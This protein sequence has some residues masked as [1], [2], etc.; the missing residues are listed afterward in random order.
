MPP[1]T[2]FRYILRRTI[3]AVGGLFAVLSALVILVDLIENM[4]FSGKVAGGDFGVALSM[5]LLRA[6]SNVQTL[7]PF[8]FLF[9]SIWMF[10]QLNKRSEI[11]V[12]RSAGLSV[13]RLLGPSA[14]I[15]A[16]SGFFIITAVDPLSAHFLSQAD[17]LK[18]RMEG[19]DRNLVRIFGDGI[20]LRQRDESGQLIINAA[21]Y[22]DARAALEKV[23]IWRFDPENTFLERLDASEAF[24]SG[25]TLELHDARL[26]A[27]GVEN[28]QFTPIYAVRTSLTSGNLRER[29]APPET[30]S[31][32][33]LPRFI[34]LA[35][36]AGVP[37]VRYN[38][39]FHDLCSTPLKLLAMVLIAAAFSM[40]PSRA[41]GALK[42]A[43]GSIVA[44]F[45]L[46][47]VSEISTALGE[48]GL[49]PAALAA[50]IPAVVASLAALTVLLHLEDG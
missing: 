36:A 44:G 13:W 29:V 9:G 19:N 21:N 32:W 46:F 47:I 49:A 39:R 27:P 38:I 48:S 41:G 5:T 24:L 22:D 14:L 30:L 45:A 28:E 25:R 26:R 18:S 6:P 35:E 34:L 17:N 23:T 1:I 33:R 50:W 16:I 4:R 11:S 12:M 43:V 42:L 2:L 15:A 40:R 31:L 7:I 3:M 10:H 8:V 20:W 37:T